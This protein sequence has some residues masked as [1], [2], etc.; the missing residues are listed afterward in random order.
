MVVILSATSQMSEKYKCILPFALDGD[1]IIFD[2]VW[3]YVGPTM[4]P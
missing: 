4:S 1:I 3:A 2:G